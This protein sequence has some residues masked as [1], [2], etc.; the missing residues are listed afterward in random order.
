MKFQ[1]ICEKFAV[2]LTPHRY[3]LRHTVGE[4]KL[5]L[6]IDKLNVQEI[7]LLSKRIFC[8][9]T[10]GSFAVLSSGIICSTY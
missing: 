6:N 4:K 2:N 7:P 1:V 5:P 8:E 9:E 3:T 10:H